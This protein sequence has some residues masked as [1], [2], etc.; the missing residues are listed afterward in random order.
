MDKYTFLRK[1]GDGTYGTVFECVDN[2]TK[3]VVAI[4]KLHRK[5]S[6]M[7]EAIALRE[8][9]SLRRLN[10]SNIIRLREVLKQPGGELWLV[11]D[12][13]KWTILDL[14]KDRYRLKSVLGLPES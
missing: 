1:C 4:K 3:E 12:F 10:H 8:V 5:L 11:F 2:Q 7:D 14:I 6:S 9:K 13:A